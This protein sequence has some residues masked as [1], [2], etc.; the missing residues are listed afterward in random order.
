MGNKWVWLYL[1]REEIKDRERE[2]RE[3][4]YFL[5]KK[6]NNGNLTLGKRITFKR[7]EVTSERKEG[8]K[9]R[10]EEKFKDEI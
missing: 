7:K 4:N 6:I 10:M 3:D 1:W 5:E 8:K 9:K 2:K